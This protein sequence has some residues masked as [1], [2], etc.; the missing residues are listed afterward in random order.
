MFGL[1][2]LEQ[3]GYKASDLIVHNYWINEMNENNIFVT[4][5]YPYGFHCV[6]HYI[7][8]VF[9]METYVILRLIAFVQTLWD[10]LMS[11]FFLKLLCKS[12][13]LPYIGSYVFVLGDFFLY[14]TYC[15]YA[16]SLPQEY[17]MM[18]ILP[19][20]YCGFMFF[21]TQRRENRGSISN[22]S[23]LYLIVFAMSISMTVTV[24]FYGAMIAAFYCMG[25]AIGFIGWIF[26]KVYF[27]KVVL[28]V[29][30]S[31][32]V[33]ILPMGIAF[34][35]G[36]PLQGS[37]QWGLGVI[38][39]Q[40]KTE[41]FESEKEEKEAIV[42]EQLEKEKKEEEEKRIRDTKDHYIE[43]YGEVAGVIMYHADSCKGTMLWGIFNVKDEN[44]QKWMYAI[45][46]LIPVLI[47]L[48]LI[49]MFIPGKDRIYCAVL[50]ST[51][52]FLLFMVVMIDSSGFGLPTLMDL[53]RGSIYFSYMICVVAVLTLDGFLYLFLSGRIGMKILQVVSLLLLIASFYGLWKGNLIRERLDSAG[54]EMNDSV[55]C[56][57][58]IIWDDKDFTW[59]IVSA[60]DE[61]RMAS[62]RGYHYELINFLWDMEKIGQRG[63]I[64][65]P[66]KTVYIFIEKV[67]GDYFLGYEGSGQRISE[68][69]CMHNLAS[70]QGL[71]S[72]QGEN[73]WITM[74]RAYAWAQ[75]FIELYP[76]EMTVYYE[77]D[78]F[79]CYKIEQNTYRL[80]NFA[81]DYDYNTR[82]YPREEES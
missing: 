18:F 60:N 46:I 81:I 12:K 36:T 80:F 53:N 42:A 59:T 63:Y 20:V 62:D 57:T 9:H 79:I 82:V 77:S 43:Q 48:G 64:R 38:V 2:Q 13:Y 14:H 24:H 33:A 78:Q 74:S 44:N 39:G 31:V 27:K 51:G 8:S 35:T 29:L 50:I 71:G 22:R 32:T 67:P 58:R 34:A 72:Y 3:Y 17:G 30:I 68:E 52:F 40:K 75:K 16:A 55:E 41:E 28:W 6:V 1:T 61:N 15:R 56:L 19:S 5:V 7:H 69:G 66:T 65:I 10:I 73:R 26:R 25:M 49:Q 21:R 76:N 23:L 11:L 4:G 47:F 45:L 70:N 37:L 54:M